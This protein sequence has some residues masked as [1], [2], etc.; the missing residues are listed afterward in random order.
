MLEIVLLST[1]YDRFATD[2]R[3]IIKLPL[4]G[5]ATISSADEIKDSLSVHDILSVRLRLEMNDAAVTR[6]IIVAARSSCYFRT[7]KASG[8]DC[9]E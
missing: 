5:I 7:C 2:N 9:K 4:F 3:A 1:W 8:T 6:V